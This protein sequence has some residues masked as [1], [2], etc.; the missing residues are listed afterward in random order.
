MSAEAAIL[1]RSWPVG[2]R[3]CT[4]SVPPPRAG[5]ARQA[6]IEWSPSSPATLSKEEW[7]Q[8][9]MGRNAAIESIADALGITVA[10]LEV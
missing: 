7:H 9:R 4:I 5:K 2:S 1:S 6:C 8:Y 10:V 3:V